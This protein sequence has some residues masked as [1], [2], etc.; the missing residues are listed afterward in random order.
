LDLLQGHGGSVPHGWVAGDDE[1]GR[2]SWSRNELRQRGERYLLAVPSNTLARDL[3]EADP[4]Y[5]GHGRR[6]VAPFRRVDELVKGLPDSAWEAIEVRDGEKGPL[7]VEGL[8]RVVQ[9]K[10]DGNPFDFPELLV[11]FRERQPDGSWKHDYLLSNAV[12]DHPLGE[13]ARGLKAEHRIEECL[14]RAKGEAGLAD[15]QVRTWAGWHHH[16]ALAVL[17]TW[18]LTQEAR[19]GKNPDPGVDGAAGGGDPGRLARPALEG[20]SGGKDDSPRQSPAQAQRGSPTLSL[21][22][23]QTLAATAI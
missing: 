6:P 13:Y 5:S 9:A 14:K 4:P 1:T 22:S 15:Y 11:V 16:Q 19:R 18:F 8:R 2:C 17:A 12:V 23:A 20:Q 7:V 21:A 10:C 3:K